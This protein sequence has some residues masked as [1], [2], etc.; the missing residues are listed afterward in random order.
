[1]TT[2]DQLKKLGLKATAPRK[3]I[4]ELFES[5]EQHHLSAEDIYRILI[6]E[7]YDIG[8]ATVYR[9]LVQFEHA[10]LLL[11]HR[12]DNDKAVFELNPGE[13][14]D[15]LIC[16]QCGRVEEFVDA[17]IEARQHAIA[18]ENGFKIREHHLTLYVD[19]IRE[20][21]PHTLGNKHL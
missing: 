19:C 16:L 3:R 12:F 13:H 18:T 11:R 10:D 4:L 8:L 6:A 9:V 21:C 20:A 1:M 15:H 14:H 7:D 5:S 2:G 17:E